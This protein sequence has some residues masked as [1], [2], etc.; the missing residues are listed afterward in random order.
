MV[1]AVCV[2]FPVNAHLVPPAG[3]E[4]PVAPVAPIGPPLGPVAP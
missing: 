2:P 1:K 4:I 3:A